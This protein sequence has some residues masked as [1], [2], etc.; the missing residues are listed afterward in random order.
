M[1]LNSNTADLSRIAYLKDKCKSWEKA[2][3]MYFSIL[4]SIEEAKANWTSSFVHYD[5]ICPAPVEGK[6]TKENKTDGHNKKKHKEF[7]CKAYQ[8]GEC[9]L[10]APHKAYV[11]AK[12]ETVL[13][14]CRVCFQKGDKAGLPEGDSACPNIA[15]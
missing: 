13:H 8:K 1:T 4:M 10:V 7:Y 15:Q 5:M 6:E 2:K 3:T 9:N 14:I 12:Q 11:A